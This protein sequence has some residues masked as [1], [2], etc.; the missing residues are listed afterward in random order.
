LLSPSSGQKSEKSMEFRDMDIGRRRTHQARP[1]PF[2]PPSPS[3]RTNDFQARLFLLTERGR[4]QV[5]TK[6]C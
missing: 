5:L 1:V 4:Q 6:H 3:I 2:R